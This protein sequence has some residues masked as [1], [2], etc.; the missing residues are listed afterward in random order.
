LVIVSNRLPVVIRRSGGTLELQATTGGLATGLSSFYDKRKMAWV[1]WPGNMKPE[2]RETVRRRL[3]TGFGYYPVFLTSSMAESYYVGF[4]N[5]TLWPLLHSFPAYTRY[6]S[7]EWTAYKNANNLF[8]DEVAKLLKPGD[9]VW[10]HDYHLMLLPSLIR[11]RVPDVKIGFFL[12]TPF[13]Q[14]DTLQLVP[15]HRQL[16]E[17]MLGADLVGFHT[18]DYV[19]AFLGS[20][21]HLLGIDNEIGRI[22]FG[23]RLVQADVFP[24]GVDFQR[25]SSIPSSPGVQSEISKIHKLTKGLKIIFS[26]GRLD[27]TKGIPQQLLALERLLETKPAQRGKIV[28]VCV[29]VPSREH[30]DLYRRLKKE[31]DELVGRINSRFS[32]I[33]WTPI[34]YM[35]R[36]L[37]SDELDALYQTAHIALVMPLRDGM[38]LVAKEFI[39][40][41]RD[42][43][44]VLVLS[45]MAGASKELLEALVVNPNDLDGVAC[46][47]DEAL[48]MPLD[49]QVARNTVMRDRIEKMDIGRWV[50]RFLVR[51]DESYESSRRLTTVLMGERSMDAIRRRYLSSRTR[52]FLLDYDG[53]LVGFS[54]KPSNASPPSRVVQLLSSL[55]SEES[56]EVFLISGRRKDDLAVWLGALPIKLVAEHGGW[57]RSSKNGRWRP[58]SRSTTEWKNQIR[59]ILE[60]FV[61]RIPGSAIEE[62]DFS[63]AWHYRECDVEIGSLAARELIDALTHLTANSDISVMA[64]NKVV[65]A[66]SAQVS[67]GLFYSKY[68]SRKRYDFVLCAGDDET[69][70]S[71][72]SMLPDDSITIKIGMSGSSA[73]YYFKD[74]DRFVDFLESLSRE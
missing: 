8:C 12:H 19:Q 14:Y 59:P 58:V 46:A 42:C 4:S 10:I 16:V 39:A 3:K 72:F 23:D 50:S 29:V 51:L 61:E 70:E 25:Y 67:K 47:L 21:R 22:V 69:D 73:K 44:G 54:S 56:N 9:T 28:Y 38:N 53:T 71:L 18:Y 7:S 31:I 36:R 32:T 30:G 5:G 68:L 26:I 60:L 64:G 43:S 1:G 13:P 57:F 65:E 24:I 11:S 2:N 33:G 63:L 27:Y 62:K 37:N 40:S 55:A 6:S 15:W 48:L 34:Q 66:K 35:Y 74:P 52:L 41:R 20:V 49:E 45:E 17:G